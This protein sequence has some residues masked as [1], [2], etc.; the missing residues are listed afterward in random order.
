VTDTIWQSKEV[1][2]SVKQQRGVVEAE[3][4]H[5]ITVE[6]GNREFC[7]FIHD[8]SCFITFLGMVQ[9]LQQILSKKV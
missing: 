8:M 6:R 2:W 5:G 3:E 7:Y 9:Y 1:W 4:D